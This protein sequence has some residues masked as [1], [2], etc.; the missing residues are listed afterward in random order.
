MT[1]IQVCV[2]RKLLE[3]QDIFS[4]ELARV[5]GQALPRFSAGSHIDVHTPAGHVRQYSL[6]DNAHTPGHYR[7]AVLRDPDSRGGSASMHAQLQ[8][9]DILTIGEPRNHFPLKDAARTVLVAGGIGITPLICMAQH[10]GAQGA[11]F[12]LHYCSRSPTRTAF[13]EEIASSALR[14]RVHFHFDD[15]PADQKLQLPSALG[16][17]VDGTHVYVC[18]PAGF[19]DWVLQGARALGFTAEQL[20]VEHFGA[21]VQD[22]SGDT[23][24]IVRIASTGQEVVVP[25]EQTVV[26]ALSEHGIEILTSCE[27][28]VCGTCITRVLEGQCDHRDLFFTEEEKARHDQFTPCC[29]RALGR[30]LILDL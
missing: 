7:I 5:D 24:F 11:D 9:G 3:A 6:L 12:E 19:I 15:G 10:L 22:T 4:F 25:A 17:A 14:E 28:G 13:R 1:D 2:H 26:Q 21:A 27:Q 29:S 18:G 30:L 20:H 23:G 8:E 16:S